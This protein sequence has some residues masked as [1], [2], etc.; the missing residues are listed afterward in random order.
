MYSMINIINIAVRYMRK[1]LGEQI[2]SSQHKE[3]FFN[4]VSLWD[5][6]CGKLTVII[7]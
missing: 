7:S 5:D 3:T 6:G 1:L 2:L 4:F